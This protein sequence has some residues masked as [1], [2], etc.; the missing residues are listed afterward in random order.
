MVQNMTVSFLYYLQTVLGRIFY[1]P[2]AF[3]FYM[4]FVGRKYKI[5][6][7]ASLREQYKA[8]MSKNDFVLICP[9]HLTMY[10]SVILAFAF[11]S[12]MYFLCSYRKLPWNLPAY[13]NFS[14]SLI[15]R[16]IT[17]LGKCIQINRSGSRTHIEHVLHRA[18]FALYKKNPVLI[19]PEG[20]R[21]R[22][23]RVDLD[24]IKYGTGRLMELHRER[25]GINTAVLCVYM[26][27]QS[28]FVYSNTPRTGETFTVDMEIITPV[29]QQRG[30]RAHREL[31]LQIGHTLVQ[32]EK[33]YWSGK[34]AS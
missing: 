20:E 15:L 22:S 7:L 17:F 26:R 33:K 13:E 14:S 19:F 11:G 4:A 28:Q 1:L 8:Y 21:S 29:T 16:V 2:L 6:N 32:L 31:S 34:Y 9:N 25:T 18:A 23:S 5:A 3:V 27:G 30:L 12:P 24:N 10:D